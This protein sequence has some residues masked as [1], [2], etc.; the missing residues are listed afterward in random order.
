MSVSFQS[1]N[2]RAITTQ[3]EASPR[4]VSGGSIFDDLF[5]RHKRLRNGFSV[6]AVT[7]LRRASDNAD[8]TAPGAS[9]VSISVMNAPAATLASWL[10][11][12]AFAFVGNSPK[13]EPHDLE[14]ARHPSSL[15]NGCPPASPFAPLAD[16]SPAPRGAL[17]SGQSRALENRPR[18]VGTLK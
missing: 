17:K 14:I 11:F 15:R 12:L 13:N 2:A 6:N 16:A 1:P 10:V 3:P 8:R 5:W 7:A 18:S 9:S 4:G